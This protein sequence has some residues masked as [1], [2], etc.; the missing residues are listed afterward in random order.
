MTIFSKNLRGA[1]PLCPPPGYAYVFP[2]LGNF[3]RTPLYA[4]DRNRQIVLTLKIYNSCLDRLCAT[5]F[6]TFLW[7][8][9]HTLEITRLDQLTN[10]CV[11]LWRQVA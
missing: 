7:V 8:L 4:T 2:P 10:R 3:L 9:I 6:M 5:H 1:W 11:K